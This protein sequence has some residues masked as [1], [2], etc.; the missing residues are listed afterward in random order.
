MN[1]QNLTDE[2]LLFL[3]YQ[4][5][6][7][8]K[9]WRQKFIG[10]LP[11]VYKRKLYEKKFLS[12][13]EFAAKLA[14]VSEEQVRR[15]L[16]LEK[17]LQNKPELHKAL[18]N[19]EVSMNKLRRIAPIATQE[20]EHLLLE[21]IKVLPQRAIETL[22][23]D[24]KNGHVPTLLQ[25]PAPEPQLSEEVKMKLY[26]LQQKGINIDE[27]ILGAIEKR[28]REISEDKEKFAE[29]QILNS[30]TPRYI[31]AKIQRLIQ[32][33]HGTKCS[34]STCQNEAEEIH[35]EIPFALLK[36]H[37]PHFLK[38]LCNA[39]HILSHRIHAAYEEMRKKAVARSIS[40][41]PRV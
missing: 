2:K 13:F 21:Q 20:N 25:E 28:N 8:T 4:Y 32:K 37:N 22:V 11:E 34:M 27:L 16:N 5:G 10:L 36:N 38:P 29:E 23:K 33:E 6:E 7:R 30:K 24:E 15:V 40:Q 26:E 9:F 35:H 17:K 1:P 41:N 14:G 12:I 19:G 39:H 3:C 18:V 31:P